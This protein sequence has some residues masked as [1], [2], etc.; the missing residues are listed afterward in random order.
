[1]EAGERL[2]LERKKKRPREA[3]RRVEARLAADRAEAARAAAEAEN[4]AV[5]CLEEILRTIGIT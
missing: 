4:T 2:D 1:M 5:E 3:A